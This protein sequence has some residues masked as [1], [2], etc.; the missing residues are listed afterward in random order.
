MLYDAVD[1]LGPVTLSKRR[2]DFD[3]GQPDSPVCL[4]QEIKHTGRVT[5]FGEDFSGSAT[6]LLIRRH[7]HFY[8]FED[9]AEDHVR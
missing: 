9:N 5:A 7:I 2:Q 4:V 8:A 3:A 1:E 6:R